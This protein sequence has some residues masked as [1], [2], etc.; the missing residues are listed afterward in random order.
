MDIHAR[1]LCQVE[2]I[3]TKYCGWSPF[4]DR[5]MHAQLKLFLFPVPRTLIAG[6]YGTYSGPYDLKFLCF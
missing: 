4:R 1:C 6:V 2:D 5:L 3:G